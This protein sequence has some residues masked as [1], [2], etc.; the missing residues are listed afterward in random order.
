[1]AGG[2]IKGG[3]RAGDGGGCERGGEERRGEGM[4]AIPHPS[5]YLSVYLSCV[6]RVCAYVAFGIGVYL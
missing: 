6:V 4:D 2:G 1:M 3:R 5:V